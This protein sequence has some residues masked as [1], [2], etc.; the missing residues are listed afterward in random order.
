MAP[1]AV[2]APDV[3]VRHRLLADVATVSLSQY[4]ESGGGA[5]M[6]AAL[7]VEPAA[8]L[9][10]LEASGL[11]GRGGAGFPTATKWRTV[12][13]FASDVLA[14]S[15]VVNAAEGEPGTFKDRLLL[16]RNPYAVLEGAMIAAHV[17]GARTIIVATKSS[18]TQTHRLRQAIAELANA[19]WNPGFELAVVEGPHEYLFGEE[20]AL[21]EVIDGR[22]PFPRT[23]P[24]W[25]RG[26]VEIV[27][28]VEQVPETA[29]PSGQPAELELASD[30]DDNVVPPVLVNNVETFANVAPIVLNGAAWFRSVGTEQ[31]PGTL[32]CTVTGAVDRPGVYEVAAGTPIG[33]VLQMAGSD[34]VGATTELGA[35]SMVLLGVSNAVL[36]ADQLGTPVSHEGFRAIGTGLGSAS[37]IV[38]GGDADPVAVAAGASQFLA[39]ESCGQCTPCKHDGL[40]ISTIL[41]ELR[42]A[43]AAPDSLER[44]DQRL[45]TVADGARCSLATQHQVVVESIRRAFPDHF[46]RRMLPDAQPVQPYLVSEL[47][48]LSETRQEIDADFAAKQ[49]DWT[50]D[51]TDSGQTP[52]ERLT[53]HRAD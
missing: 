30:A 41:R 22:P 2:S 33:E 6:R 26:V 47:V 20:T 18:F 7:A 32:L 3:D 14:T 50:Y 52:V 29:S 5:A 1:T 45:A 25:R 19:A 17:V 49:P 40:D 37:F 21:L 46:E 44:L 9:D 13:S 16:E 12:M 36:R 28:D 42:E 11:R 35:P 24:P 23:A 39:V 31:T 27:D 53:D 43:T 8:V 10:E 4:E 38:I 51:P 34:D 48:E 15:V